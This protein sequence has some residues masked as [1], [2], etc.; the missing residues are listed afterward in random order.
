MS[1]A[2]DPERVSSHRL[3][4]LCVRYDVPPGRAHDALADA[5]ATAAVLPHLLRGL[6]VTSSDDLARY[7]P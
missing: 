4:D 7:A 2:L 1:R 3:A 5:T 6:G